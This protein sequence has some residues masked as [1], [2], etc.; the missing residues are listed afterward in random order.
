MH[1]HHSSSSLLELEQKQIHLFLTDVRPI[2]EEKSD[3][4]P[5][6]QYF[7]A[8]FMGIAVN[9]PHVLSRIA[10]RCKSAAGAGARAR[11][12]LSQSTALHFS[13]IMFAVT[14]GREMLLMESGVPGQRPGVVYDDGELKF[15]DRDAADCLRFAI[16]ATRH[17]RQDGRAYPA[18]SR[19]LGPDYRILSSEDAQSIAAQTRSVDEPRAGDIL[20][21]MA[22]VRALSFLMEAETREALMVHGPY[23][24]GEEKQQLVIF[25]CNDLRWPLFPHF[26]ISG[27]VRWALPE[28]P[29]PTANLAIALLLRDVEVRADRFGTLYI[30]PL[31]PANLVAASLLTRGSD[32]YCDEGL[33]ELPLSETVSLRRLCDEIQESMFLQIAGWDYRQRLEAGVFQE[34][35]YALRLLAGAGYSLIEIEREQKI[36]FERCARV[37]GRHFDEILAKPVDQLP[38]YRKLGAFIADPARGL[39]TPFTGAE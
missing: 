17:Y 18:D 16:Q 37:Y 12:V 27:G 30:E 6:P 5:E 39:F 28:R 29:F 13:G 24:V 8:A 15:T 23:P 31:G 25:E 36:L 9:L 3:L 14:W 19:A 2:G 10:E 32:P 33:R 20:G 7:N 26:P 4:Y 1:P 38:F 21:L 11:R 34:E 22:A 35:T